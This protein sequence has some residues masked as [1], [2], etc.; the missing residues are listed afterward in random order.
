MK[1]YRPFFF[2]GQEGIVCPL[3][4]FSSLAMSLII[5]II[6]IKGLL[7]WNGIIKYGEFFFL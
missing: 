4:F 7:H 1:A 2:F 5:I 6:V 3:L